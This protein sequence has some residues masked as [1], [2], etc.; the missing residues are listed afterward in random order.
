M[1]SE[2]I[3]ENQKVHLTFG[4]LCVATI[5]I[6]L[7]LIFVGIY[8]YDFFSAWY[9]GILIPLGVIV[10]ILILVII[11]TAIKAVNERKKDEDYIPK[12]FF[13][14]LRRLFRKKQNEEFSDASYSSIPLTNRNY[15][16]FGPGSIDQTNL[17]QQLSISIVDTSS[18]ISINSF[19]F[20]G[21]AGKEKCGICKLAFTSGDIII[22]CPNCKKLYHKEHLES[23]F[24]TNKHC[25]ICDYPFF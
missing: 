22:Q 12:P 6:S 2:K 5:I 16:R 25:P 9:L 23:W 15:G 13:T 11:S 19:I 7:V 24:Q 21:K 1:A 18:H 10:T 4:L 8:G 20:E 17:N 3:P 14:D